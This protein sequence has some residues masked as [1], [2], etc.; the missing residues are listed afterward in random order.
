[1]NDSLRRQFEEQR[2]THKLWKDSFEERLGRL[3]LVGK[4]N[5]AEDVIVKLPPDTCEATVD[6]PQA[7]ADNTPDATVG[8]ADTAERVPKCELAESIWDS[9]LF[10][11]RRDI[12]MGRIVTLWAVFVLLLNILLQ[13]TIAV[14][15][16][17][18]MG[19]PTFV[20]HIIE[21]L[22]YA[23]ESRFAGVACNLL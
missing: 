18:N 14:I 15:V 20:A 23:S 6:Q 22:W 17:L 7:V 2:S 16:L 10:L 4:A 21:D 19:D 12:G 1:L 8:G 5:A 13:T 11:G 3:E 9:P